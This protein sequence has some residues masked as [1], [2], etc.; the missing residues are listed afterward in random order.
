[1]ETNNIVDTGECIHKYIV[2]EMLIGSKG[3]QISL[4]WSAKPTTPYDRFR[5][6]CW[7]HYMNF[8]SSTSEQRKKVM[9]FEFSRRSCEACKKLGESDEI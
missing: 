2:F 1:M 9:K 5:P 7:N 6:P 4:L 8:T 3:D